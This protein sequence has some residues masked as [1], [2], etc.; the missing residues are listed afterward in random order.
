MRKADANAPYSF[1]RFNKT[2]RVPTFSE[3]VYEVCLP[4]ISTGVVRL[5][6]CLRKREKERE[7]RLMFLFL[8]SA[9]RP[10]PEQRYLTS[11]TWTL[12]ETQLLFELCRRFDRRFIIVHDRFMR[13]CPTAAMKVHFPHRHPLPPI[14]PLLSVTPPYPSSFYLAEMDH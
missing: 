2:V 11:D 3:E 6:F 1:A 13:L 4:A 10:H 7:E 14:F 8:T 12:E 5:W 9:L